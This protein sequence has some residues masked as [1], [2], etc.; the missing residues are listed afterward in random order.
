MSSGNNDY[1]ANRKANGYHPYDG[2][3]AWGIDFRFDKEMHEVVGVAAT[4]PIEGISVSIKNL[5]SE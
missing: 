2:L 5:Q 4:G 1:I 3:W